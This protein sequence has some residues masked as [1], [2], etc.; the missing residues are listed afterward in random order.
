MRG[1]RNAVHTNT[2]A[3]Y[4]EFGA[5]DWNSNSVVVYNNN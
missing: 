4:I 5:I 3:K 1:G 2:T